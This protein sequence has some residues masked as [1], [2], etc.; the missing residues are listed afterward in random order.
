VCGLSVIFVLRIRI[1][2][3]FFDGLIYCIFLGC[4]FSPCVGVFPL[5]SFE[6][7]DSSKDM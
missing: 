5:L 2:L 4:N 3:R 6:R 7:L 1:L